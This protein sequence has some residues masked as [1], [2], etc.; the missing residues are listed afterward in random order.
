M[1]LIADYEEWM[2]S[3]RK[4]PRTI[5]DRIKTL[6][7][8]DREL[9]CGLEMAT[10]QEIE[11]WVFRDEWSDNTLATYFG[12]AKAFFVWATASTAPRLSFN[13]METLLPPDSPRGLPRPVT[14]SQLEHILTAAIEPYRTWSLLAAYEGLRCMEISG[15]Q[16]EHITEDRLRVVAG[17]GGKEGYVPTHPLVWEAVEPLPRGPIAWTIRG[18]HAS[19]D[20]VSIRTACYFRR[21]LGLPGVGLHMLRHWFGTNLMRQTKN[22][23]TVQEMMRHAS[24]NTTAVY[25]LVTSEERRAATLTLPTFT[26]TPPESC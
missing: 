11:A 18:A 25:T 21:K 15:L 5:D 12:H 7:R 1:S 24:P 8:M 4:R 22:L 3:R 23:R 6:R 19:P 13:P 2:R 9:P 16:R 20:Y 14:D 10:G 17:K 26:T